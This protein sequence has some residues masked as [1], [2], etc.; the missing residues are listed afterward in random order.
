MAGIF[1]SPT[2]GDFDNDGDLTFTSPPYAPA[3]P[4]SRIS[5]C[6]TPM[7][8]TGNSATSPPP[9][10][11]TTSA[12]PQAAWGDIDNDGDLDLVTAGKLFLNENRKG[13]WLTL[14]LIGDGKT[15]NRSAVGAIALCARQPHPHPP[16]RNR[17]RRRQPKR[18]PPPLRSWRAQGTVTVKSPAGRSKTVTK[19]LAV[20]QQHTVKFEV[21]LLLKISGLASGLR[22]CE[23]VLQPAA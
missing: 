1:A 5:P 21:D 2:L 14:T 6:S 4:A 19:E 20:N 15:M 3:A 13:N 23:S 16:R 7:T 11:S 10:K 18:P 22:G 9:K 17:H 12:P 8:A